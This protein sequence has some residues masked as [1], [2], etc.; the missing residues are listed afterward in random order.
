MQV[1]LSGLDVLRW[2]PGTRSLGPGSVVGEKGQK[3]KKRGQIGKISASEEVVSP[4]AS[5]A[6]FFPLF[7]PNAEPGPRPEAR[8][9]KVVAHVSSSVI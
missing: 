8:K 1:H 3:G 9:E 2:S 5:L 4:L 6:D 7:A